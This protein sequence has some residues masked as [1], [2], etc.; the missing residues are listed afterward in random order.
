M[1]AQPGPFI[2]LEECDGLALYALNAQGQVFSWDFN[3]DGA[4][5]VELTL[6]LP[7]VSMSI[8]LP[9]SAEPAGVLCLAGATSKSFD[10]VCL[11]SVATGHISFTSI[12]ATDVSVSD[13]GTAWALYDVD[14]SGAFPTVTANILTDPIDF[15]P[16]AAVNIKQLISTQGGNVIALGAL[17]PGADLSLLTNG[18]SGW[19]L[20]SPST[21]P[22][23]GAPASITRS[24]IDELVVLTENGN[25]WLYF[26]TDPDVP[27][28][29][30]GWIRLGDGSK[31]YSFASM[32]TRYAWVLDDQ[33]IAAGL[34]SL[35]E[36]QDPQV[37]WD[38]AALWD[39]SKSTHLFIV[40]RGAEYALG[41]C[42]TSSFAYSTIANGMQP[43]ADQPSS[44][45]FRTGM[46][47][48]LYD[49]D[50]K[51]AFVQP[52][53]PG[54]NLNVSRT[55]TSHFYNPTTGKNY[56]GG[57]DHALHRAFTYQQMS[58]TEINGPNGLS[59]EAGYYLG[60]ALHYFTDLTQPMHAADYTYFS[61]TPYGYHSYFEEYAMSIQTVYAPEV[62]FSPQDIAVSDFISN[63]A[64]Y[65][66]EM[67]QLVISLAES[68]NPD[69]Y[70]NQDT[71]HNA[72]SGL[73]PDILSQAV[74]ATAQFIY[75]V[76]SEPSPARGSAP[77]LDAL[78]DQLRHDAERA[79]T[80]AKAKAR[81]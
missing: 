24:S 17:T 70:D 58:M 57:S 37:S 9:T 60:L 75:S 67:S 29:P 8:I 68:P 30:D 52:F 6:P 48:G 25:L 41:G 14:P 15:Q 66:N 7:I 62:T 73:L 40:N 65:F 78:G 76:L 23:D 34:G 27:T 79:S 77:A 3:T 10:Q 38:T 55:Y 56:R 1:P 2:A 42:L 35:F 22:N 69:W 46:V 18:T 31:K 11:F 51:A 39:E 81:R 80:Q 45:D 21:L 61:S 53:I 36:E 33:G 71:W 59:F 44:S 32:R 54:F 26:P 47:N 50:F 20:A 16:N 49:A 72:V 12:L 74:E 4:S 28:D 5:W 19:E 13:D 43:F 64:T 63:T